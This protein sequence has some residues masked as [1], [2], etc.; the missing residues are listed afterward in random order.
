MPAKFDT[1]DKTYFADRKSFAK[2]YSDA[3]F[4][5]I[6]DNWPL[7]AGEVNIAR[8]LAI[9]E[10]AKKVVHLPGHFAEFGCWNGTNLLFMAK[11]LSILR[12]RE[13]NKIFGFDSFEGLT[14]FDDAK[15][16]D[17]KTQGKYKGNLQL[18]QDALKLHGFQDSVQ[19]IKGNI[20]ETVPAFVQEKKDLRF[21]LI[22]VD[23]DLYSPTKT[24]LQYLY[25]KLLSG[26]IMVF[27]EYNTE[28]WSGE[29]SAVHDV[30]GDDVVIQ[31]V[32]FTRQPTAYITK[33]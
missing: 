10:L 23:V 18:L 6:A 2:D 33:K 30:L 15:D 20:D 24:I 14:T 5:F 1:V 25:P 9:Y 4:W 19:L 7:L 13:L 8:F 16:T 12:P 22:Y 31:K 11:V 26:G 3:D 17:R 32:P 21:S 27:D 28:A 29:T